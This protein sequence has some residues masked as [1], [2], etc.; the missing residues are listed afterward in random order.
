MSPEFVGDAVKLLQ[1]F[2]TA[3]DLAYYGEGASGVE[4]LL[5]FFK[6][7]CSTGTP[8]THKIMQ[9]GVTRLN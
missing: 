9:V 6:A 7:E 1:S 2:I 3:P 4:L 5:D 8:D